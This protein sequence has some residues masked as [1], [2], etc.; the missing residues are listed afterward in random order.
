MTV[1]TPAGIPRSDP[2][3]PDPS[4]SGYGP[5]DIVYPSTI[6]FVLVHIACI[7]AIWTGV[8][9]QALAI[10]AV[11]YIVRI[12]AIGAGYHRYFSHRAF[13]TSRWFQ[14]VLALLAQ[15]TT[16]KGV[17]WWAAK[18]RHHHRWSDTEFDVHSP[19]QVG[20][21]RAHVGWIFTP[22]HEDTDLSVVADL[23]RYPELVWLNRWANAPAVALAVLCFLLGGWSGLVVGFFWSTVLLYHAT[24]CIN[25]LAH[26]HGRRR[27]V[28]GDDSRNNWFLAI[29]T[30]G[31]GWH[32]NH[33][34]YQSAARQGFRWW[35]YDPTYYILKVLS[36]AGIVW[37]LHQPPKSVVRNE[38]RLGRKVIEKAAAQLAASFDTGR[39][40]ARLREAMA[41]A[42]GRS[43]M[44][45]RL[46][47]AR[48]AAGEAL[49]G[50]Q[51]PDLHLPH[52][53]GREEIRQRA[54]KMFA[55]TPSLD[56]IVD[57]AREM[58]FDSVFAEL[59]PDRVPVQ[60]RRP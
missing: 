46:A 18:H 9:W 19:R 26:V 21:W 1:P 22:R 31:E 59:E 49:A 41:A 8:T 27:Y 43:G 20:F 52:L 25:S 35:E 54:Q 6:P 4:S 36:W 11:L 24:F 60:T 47:Q 5:D 28:T 34:A 12:F 48:R 16:Q 56:D 2:G 38:Q 55:R 45:D 57:R 14:F 39:I 58:L 50:L 42:P 29:L 37:D 51:M 53:P 32:N 17:L 7:A 33:H 30:M 44:E 15:S 23:A 40:A 3:R 13:K 10:C